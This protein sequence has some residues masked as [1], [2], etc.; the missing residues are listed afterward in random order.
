MK[1][2]L[3]VAALVSLY[4]CAA[5][6][7]SYQDFS[8]SSALTEMKARLVLFR[9]RESAIAS[10]RT[11]DVR[12]DGVPAAGVRY[13]GFAFVEVQPGKRVLTVD[14]PDIRGQCDLPVDTAAGKEYYFEVKP[15]VEGLG[16]GLIPTL[17]VKGDQPWSP[18]RSD[19]RGAFYVV[20]I[21]RND[22]LQKLK[23]LK[24]SSN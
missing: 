15:R 19:C 8:Q 1:L 3:A 21:E 4:G 17:V 10:V 2:P 24:L 22:A 20:P 12:I 9:T 11:A 23:D 5:T 7:P 16:M 13:G 6:G 18:D 14:L